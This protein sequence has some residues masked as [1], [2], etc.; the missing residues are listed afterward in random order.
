[1]TKPHQHN[2]KTNKT[3]HT[4]AAALRPE[5]TGQPVVKCKHL[6][7][8]PAFTLRLFLG[9]FRTYGSDGRGYRS[10]GRLC[11]PGSAQRWNA[12]QTFLSATATATSLHHAPAGSPATPPTTALTHLQC[13]TDRQSLLLLLMTAT[14]LSAD[15]PWLLVSSGGLTQHPAFSSNSE[16]EP[17]FP[18]DSGGSTHDAKLHFANQSHSDFVLSLSAHTVEPYLNSASLRSTFHTATAHCKICAFSSTV[19]THL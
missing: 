3:Q 2:T 5:W 10:D 7:Q 4:Q 13:R 11:R 6:T 15:V 17:Q 9:S 1:M 14:S 18:A 19:Y 12:P 16:M 8:H